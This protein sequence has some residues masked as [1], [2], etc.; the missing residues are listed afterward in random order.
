MA[1][2]ALPAD[3]LECDSL[4]LEE[5]AAKGG[6]PMTRDEVVKLVTGTQVVWSITQAGERRWTNE[7]GGS[8]WGTRIGTGAGSFNPHHKSG[9][10]KWLV[11][12]DG[13]Y[14]VTI[15]YSTMIIES[16]CWTFYSAQSDG[17]VLVNI[18]PPSVGKISLSR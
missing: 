11:K 13:V 15:D 4:S 16:S 6:T 9:Q 17:H 12:D 14:C 10:G 8:F 1:A 7:P 5:I 2:R 18:Q 3:A